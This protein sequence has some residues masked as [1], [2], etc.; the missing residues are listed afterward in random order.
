MNILKLPN[1]NET[2]LSALDFFVRNNPHHL[3][4]KLFTLPIV[5]GSGNAFNTAQIIFSGRPAII[6]N[7]SNFKTILSGYKKL[8][9][10]KTISQAIIISASG[11]KDSI[12]EIKLAKKS[13][14][15]TILL[16][17]SPDSS[18]AKLADQVITYKKLPEPYTYNVSTYLGIILS[19]G[20]EEARGIKEFINKIKLPANFRNFSSFSFILPDEFGAISP[21]L[22]IK[23]NEL[24]G[25]YI[26]LRAFSFGEARHAKFVN[27]SDKELV[28]SFGENKYFGLKK[29]RWEIKTPRNAGNSFI[30][31]LSYYLIGKIQESKTPYF[32]KNLANFCQE[33]PLAY[34]SKKPFD[35]IVPG[36]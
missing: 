6:A 27:N 2:V 11:E 10:N 5:V 20:R 35:M 32:K 24:F 9:S 19:A 18:A 25:P 22:E 12:W 16:T 33:G 15:K 3:N 31:A 34:G 4:L 7:E 21:M 29:N 1:L 28:I 8:I 26:S 23:R 30:M 17:C 13:K 14:L 36:N